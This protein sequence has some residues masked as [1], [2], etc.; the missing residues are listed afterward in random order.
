MTISK[1]TISLLVLYRKERHLHVSNYSMVRIKVRPY[2][3]YDFLL[4]TKTITPQKFRTLK[5]EFFYVLYLK[6][7]GK[8]RFF[9]RKLSFKPIL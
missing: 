6:K 1:V 3:F 2:Y 7:K 4:N 9:L 5:L 8:H